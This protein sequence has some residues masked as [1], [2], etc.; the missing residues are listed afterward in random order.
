MTDHELEDRL[1]ETCDRVRH[2]PKGGWQVSCPLPNHGQG[3]GD[4]NPS[5]AVTL[6]EDGVPLVRCHALTC[7]K[8]EVF[9]AVMGTQPK[10]DYTPPPPTRNSRTT[11]SW[12]ESV[13]CAAGTPDCGGASIRAVMPG[14][15]DWPAM[16]CTCGQSS[17]ADLLD[18]AAA[19]TE[20]VCR[21]RYTYD[22]GDFAW[23][24]RKC[25]PDGGKE[26]SGNRTNSGLLVSVLTPM[27]A[28]PDTPVVLA[29]GE[30]AAA[31]VGGAG[32]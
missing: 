1:H 21:W 32:D 9:H 11:A 2:N 26:C 5:V 6:S 27:S 10:P 17:Y 8:D 25:L 16:R 22:S 12:P 7:D 3:R 18:S 24:I 23:A 29:E 19:Q 31:D 14:I 13:P 30:K 20:T 28:H 4:R 15:V